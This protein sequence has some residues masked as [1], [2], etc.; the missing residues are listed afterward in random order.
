MSL[1][2][3]KIKIDQLSPAKYNPRK[4]LKPGD[5]EYE[6]LKKSILQFGYVDPIIV[7]QRNNVVIGGH[8]RL[9]I[10]RDIGYTEVD[11]SMVD[12]DD[13]KE[14]ALNIA[15]NKISGDWDMALLKDLLL[16]L[17]TGAFDMN[18]IG[19]DEDELE[20]LMTQFHVGEIKE[21]DF[22][23]DAVA[24]EIKEPVTKRGDIWLLGRHR[25][26]CGDST[27]LDDVLKLMDNNLADMVFTDP[28]YNVDYEGGSGL[29]IMND[30][31]NNE[32]FYK[33]LFDAFKAMF[34]VTKEGGAIYICHADSEGL[35]F[36][37]SMIDAGWMMK[38]C[39]IWVKNSMVMGRQ[40][41]H[42]KHEPILYGWKPGA[43]HTWN[44]N[45]KQTTI[46][47]NFAG[48]TVKNEG[49][50]TILSFSNGVQFASIKVPSFE[51]LAAGDDV[52]TSVWRIEKPLK[53]GEHPTM[54]PIE[55]CARAIKN[56]SLVQH[57]ILDLFGGS[58]STLI[59][60]EQI[61]RSC[62]V[63]ELDPIYCDVII[64]RYEQ[65]T[66]NKAALIKG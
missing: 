49:K 39:L 47:D 23:A 2:I 9:K 6:Q 43:A 48:I 64:K 58:G 61:N 18:S 1:L 16:E 45:R 33:F 4:D 22:D 17:D 55:L 41:Y 40:D 42:W 8:Q 29:K 53:N 15:L 19:F 59:A 24:A 31:M 57:R 51:I 7:N 3:E 50:E 30:K 13:D 34:V 26:M 54:K 27:N 14:K 65:F 37:K 11:A 21:D 36:R 56:S 46:I 38:Q 5:K 63:M 12:L 44:N 60:T 52:D 66:G 20:K 62:Y 10:L 32:N 25:L 28:P 35:N